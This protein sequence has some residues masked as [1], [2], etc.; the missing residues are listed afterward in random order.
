MV[1][2]IKVITENEYQK[3]PNAIDLPVGR[4][5]HDDHDCVM[6]IIWLVGK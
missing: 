1:Q 6:K 5:R 4:Q 3:A 2:H